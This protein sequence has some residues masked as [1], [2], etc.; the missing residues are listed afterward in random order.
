MESF[1]EAKTTKNQEKIVLKNMCSFS[2][3]FYSFFFGFFGF[4]LD[5]GRPQAVQKSIKI[6]KNRV[7]AAFGARLGFFIDFRRVLGGF[8]E[9]SGTVSD[10]FWKDFGLI[11]KDF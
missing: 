2:F 7:R 5:F 8:W 10:E 1:S 9:G 11:F 4:W 6:Q 3:D